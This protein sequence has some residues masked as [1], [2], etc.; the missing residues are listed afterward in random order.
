MKFSKPLFILS[1]FV[2]LLPALVGAYPAEVPRTGQT[3]CYDYTGTIINCAGTGQDGNMLAGV[4][5]PNPRFVDNGDGTV[6]DKLTGLEWSKDANPAGTF[7]T[8]QDALDYVKT[9]N[10]GS[11]NDWRLPNVNE[12]ESLINAEASDQGL[13]TG[14]PFTNVQSNYY[15]TSTSSFQR[16][17]DPVALAWIVG[18]FAGSLDSSYK[19]GR[20]Y[21]VWPLRAG[22]CEAFGNSSICLPKTGQTMCYDSLGTPIDC[23]GTGQD[24]AIQAG[25]VWPDPRFSDRGDGTVADNLTGL[26]WAKNAN[27]MP[28]RDSGWDNDETANDGAVTWQHTL[29]YVAKL[30]NESYLGYK[31]WRLPNKRELRSLIDYSKYNP[32]LPQNHPFTNVQFTQ[33]LYSSSSTPFYEP[34][35]AFMVGF[36]YGFYIELPKNNNNYYYVWPVRSGQCGSFDNSTTTTTVGSTTSVPTTTTIAIT[37][38]SIISSTTTTG[39]TTTTIPITDADWSALGSGMDNG[40]S[41]LAVDASGNVYAGGAFTTAGGV[42]ANHIAKWDGSNWSALGSGLDNAY[43][44]TSVYALA[45]DAS[46]N[47]YAGGDFTTAGGR[48]A[49]DIAKWDGSNW[50]ALGSG[51]TDFVEALAIDGSGNVYAGGYFHYA[52]GV[53]AAIIAKW[54]G[55]RWSAVGSGISGKGAIVYA[56]A[57]DA[58]GNLYAGGHFV[59]SG[60]NAIVSIAKWDGSRWSAMGSELYANQFFPSVYALAVDASGNLYAGGDF[61]IAGAELVNYIAKWDGMSWSA[62][63]SGMNNYV[64]ALAVDGSGYLY[65]GGGFTTAGGKAAPY[66]ARCNIPAPCAVEFFPR[67]LSKVVDTVMHLQAIIIRGDENTVFSSAAKINWGT[68]SVETIMQAVLFKRIVIALVLVNGNKQKVGDIYEVTVDNCTGELPVKMF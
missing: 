9:L 25:V 11:H 36:N 34:S 50:S 48:T 26:V 23:V 12:L 53:Y 14:H 40:V 7:M 41:A 24:G 5:W 37:T 44:G 59:T 21:L 55:S 13:P 42:S 31:D 54:G 15:C 22:Q 60:G 49:Y 68:N 56:L 29:D 39:L 8:W 35:S 47:L 30:N 63:G 33:Q 27:L 20:L 65:A 62:L 66:I 67:S 3:T 43:H 45:V 38:T 52:G 18:I 46:G 32:A 57:L 64:Y 19:E 16:Y 10:T 61:K 17:Y 51:T 1:I 2:T 6:T 28:A 58:S 4:P